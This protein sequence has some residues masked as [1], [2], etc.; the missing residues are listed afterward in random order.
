MHRLS[1]GDAEEGY[2]IYIGKLYLEKYHSN[3]HFAIV[4]GCK[5]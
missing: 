1:K 5:I 4:Y 3:Q 2:N